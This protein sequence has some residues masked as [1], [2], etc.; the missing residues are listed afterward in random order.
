MNRLK[1]FWSPP[2]RWFVLGGIATVVII[3]VVIAGLQLQTRGNQG[4]T[5]AKSVAAVVE[6]GALAGPMG[7]ALLFI[8]Q[9]ELSNLDVQ[10][11]QFSDTPGMLTAINLGT[12]TAA[13]VPTNTE[14]PDGVVVITELANVTRSGQSVE[15]ELVATR[16]SQQ[17]NEKLLI[18][19]KEAFQ[20]SQVKNFLK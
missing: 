16:D 4:E 2:I 9:E 1:P 18:Q 20:N 5:Q 7:E 15:Y 11:L 14:L 3:V 13:I 10:W 12:A 19:L 17:H 8:R 6:I